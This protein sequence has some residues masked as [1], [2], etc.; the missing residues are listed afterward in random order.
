MGFNIGGVQGSKMVE[1][2]GFSAFSEPRR[3]IEVMVMWGCRG[4]GGTGR[5]EVGNAHL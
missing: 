5:E 2:S 4:V 3:L 1:A